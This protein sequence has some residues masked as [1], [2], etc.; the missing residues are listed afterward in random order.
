MRLP[1]VW[2]LT[3]GEA[4]MR[5]QVLGLCDRLGF[6]FTE[7]RI[8]LRA[9]WR[10]FPGHLCPFPLRGLAADSDVIAPPW[11]DL[12]ISCG[13]RSTAAAI[14]IRR[15]SHRRT[16]TV[17]LQN[18]RTPTDRFD[19]VIAHPHDGIS[20]TNVILTETTIHRV[21]PEKLK[22]AATQFSMR[23]AGLAPPRLAVLLGG[24]TRRGGFSSDDITRFIA[25]LAAFRA[26]GHT[27]MITPSR[28][29]ES[30][31]REAL[32]VRFAHD[33]RVALWDG[34]GDNPYFGMLALADRFLVT[35][36]S[37][38]MVSE[39]LSTGKPVDLFNFSGMGPRHHL[40]ARRL[41]AQGHVQC[42]HTDTDVVQ[43][44]PATTPP[45]DAASVAE[46]RIRTLLR[47]RLEDSA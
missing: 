11:P 31:L 36:D 45:P 27:I 22:A 8:G 6:A 12:L 41:A 43:E 2:A 39:A 17:H 30:A 1:T 13:R 28:R 24:R 42:L 16:L 47:Q 4:G 35:A 33:P 18:P 15:A 10:W 38:S 5:S 23:Y 34:S 29:T 9:P 25:I 37:T 46:K 26:Q 14:A 20:G 3:T 7:K 44:R 32:A 21:T 40:F 19:L